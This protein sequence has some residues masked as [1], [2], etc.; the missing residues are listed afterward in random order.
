MVILN[1][2]VVTYCQ[3]KRQGFPEVE[4]GI[5]WGNRLYVLYATFSLD[6]EQ[7]ASFYVQ[8]CRRKSLIVHE[9]NHYGVWCQLPGLEQVDEPMP[10]LVPKSWGRLPVRTA[11]E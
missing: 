1:K 3:V 7:E 9:T 5:R 10:V 6:E 4:T 8:T 11:A 2:S